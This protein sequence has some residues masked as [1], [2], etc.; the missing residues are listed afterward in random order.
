M[1][2]DIDHVLYNENVMKQLSYIPDYDEYEELEYDADIV[3]YDD[4]DE[5]YN[6]YGAEADG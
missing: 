1:S 6:I 2:R 3:D 4:S 5:W